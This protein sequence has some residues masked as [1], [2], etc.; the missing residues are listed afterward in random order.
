MTQQLDVNIARLNDQ[1]EAMK[2]GLEE[3][4]FIDAEYFSNPSPVMQE[5]ESAQEKVNA[6]SNMARTYS[7]YQDL[8]NIQSYGNKNLYKV[9]EVLERQQVLWKMVTK[10]NEQYD[11]WMTEDFTKVCR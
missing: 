1:L 11:R 4:I 8:F 3:G 5:L 6:L 10:W 7:E 9:Q 2:H